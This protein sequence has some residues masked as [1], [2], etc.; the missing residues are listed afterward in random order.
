M[1]LQWLAASTEW[2]MLA[3]S[4]HRCMISNISFIYVKLF[5]DDGQLN[6]SKHVD[7]DYWNKLRER[8]SEKAASC[9]SLLGKKVLLVPLK[10]ETASISDRN[11]AG[12]VLREF[13]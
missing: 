2:I 5:P 9:W 8:E 11:T 7:D 4:Q 6:Y 1:H 3:A 13:H 10:M 12:A